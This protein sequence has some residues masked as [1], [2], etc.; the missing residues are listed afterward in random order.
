LAPENLFGGLTMKSD[1]GISQWK[2]RSGEKA[3]IENDQLH[4]PPISDHAPDNALGRYHM[5][6]AHTSNSG[7]SC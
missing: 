4:Y 3:K 1:F 6:Y 7:E 5:F 2:R